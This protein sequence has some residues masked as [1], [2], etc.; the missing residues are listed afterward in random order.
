[1]TNSSV[2][3]QCI[4]V[5]LSESERRETTPEGH[6]QRSSTAEDQRATK[7]AGLR[8]QEGLDGRRR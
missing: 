2:N 1:M 6:I 5:N 4:H 7:D 8:S 3:K